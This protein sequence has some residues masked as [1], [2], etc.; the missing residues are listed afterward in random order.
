MITYGLRDRWD[1][2][3]TMWG[4]SRDIHMGQ[5]GTPPYKGCP[6]CP[7]SGPVSSTCKAEGQET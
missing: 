4:Q 3:G 7:V 2:D 6:C 5:D 1:N